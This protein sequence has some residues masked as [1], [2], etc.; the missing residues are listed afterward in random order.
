MLVVLSTA[1]ATGLLSTVPYCS[2][3]LVMRTLWAL[4]MAW[5]STLALLLGCRPLVL[6]LSCLVSF[7]V[8]CCLCLGLERPGLICSSFLDWSRPW[9]RGCSTF[10]LP[11]LHGASQFSFCSYALTASPTGST[12][13]T[14]AKVHIRTVMLIMLSLLPEPA[15][16]SANCCWYV[17][18]CAVA[19]VTTA[20]TRYIYDE[21]AS[22]TLDLSGGANLLVILLIH[23]IFVAASIN[24]PSAFT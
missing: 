17:L 2:P 5:L 1:V 10:P 16:A 18:Q 23:T 15:N 19:M 6:L 20:K 12:E 7:I 4:N 8:R 11:S 3:S 22:L 21:I 9:C 13:S 24:Y 14:A